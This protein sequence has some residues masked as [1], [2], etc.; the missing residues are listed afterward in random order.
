MSHSKFESVAERLGDRIKRDGPGCLPAIHRLARE[1]RVSYVTMWKA[2]RLLADQGILAGRKGAGTLALDPEQPAGIQLSADRFAQQLESGVLDG[3]YP[4]G[5]PMPK[6][7][8]FIFNERVSRATVSGAFG[9]LSRRNMIYKQGKRWIAG[10]R[11]ARSFRCAGGDQPVVLIVVPH[12][13]D[14]YNMNIGGFMQPYISSFK[15]EFLRN[16]ISLSLVQQEKPAAGTTQ[17]VGGIDDVRALVRSLGDRYRGALMFGNAP[18]V[19]EHR[20][21]VAEMSPAGKV[22]AVYFDSAGQGGSCVRSSMGGNRRYFRMYLDEI[23]GVKLALEALAA[24]GHRTIGMPIMSIRGDWPQRRRALSQ[25]CAARM[26]P[27]ITI[28]A[29]DQDEPFWDIGIDTTDLDRF[30]KFNARFDEYVAKI[31]RQRRETG[32]FRARGRRF[33]DHTPSMAGLLDA[34]VTALMSPN[35]AMAHE[36]YSW[37]RAAGIDVPGRLSI[38]SFDN[39]PNAVVLPVSTIDFGFA[40]LGYI[41][42]H[43]IIGDIPL[44]ADREGGIPGACTLVDRGSVGRP[45][46]KE[47]SGS[48]NSVELRRMI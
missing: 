40:Q 21:W 23:G 46:G 31:N 4:A 11:P 20:D 42:A 45:V 48:R 47:N 33:I 44:R 7:D 15:N 22:P 35:D 12:A 2:V 26:R 41:A 28:V 1:Y 6:F 25:E 13:Y 9:R 10:P 24:A 19:R 29:A 34:G 17:V 36:H 38:I 43:I 30:T 16:G 8:Y 5:R 18:D 39:T 14:W 3:K 32:G 37:C 27:A